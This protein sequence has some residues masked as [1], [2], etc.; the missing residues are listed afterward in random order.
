MEDLPSEKYLKFKQFIEETVRKQPVTR[1]QFIEFA[2]HV[3]KLFAERDKEIKAL[4]ERLEHLEE[5]CKRMR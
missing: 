2:E 4:I 3:D 1:E 5:A